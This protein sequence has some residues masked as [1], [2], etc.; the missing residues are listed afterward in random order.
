M[1]KP[2]SKRRAPA[3]IPAA[4]PVEEV[5]SSRHLA[6]VTKLRLAACS[7]GRCQFRGHNRD[8]Y[9]H[10]VT[11]TQGNYAEAA[12]IVAFRPR[13]ARGGGLRPK[14]INDFDNLMLLCRDCHHIVDTEPKNYPVEVLLQYKKEH[15]ERILELTEVGPEYRTTVV[16]LRGTIGGQAVDI[17]GTDIR[18]ALRP[19]YPARLPGVLIDL[20]AIQREDPSFFDLARDQIARE[21]RPAIRAE[22]ERKGVQHY[23]VFALAPI[24]VLV[25]LGREIGN[26]VTTDVFQKQRDHS[27]CWKVDG[28]VAEFGFRRIREG[29][30]GGLVALQ[31][32]VSGQ[33]SAGSLPGQLVH[34][35]VWE[36]AP[37]GHPPGVDCVRRREDLEAFRKSYRDCLTA[38]DAAYGKVAAI[39]LLP[40][41]PAPIAVACGQEIMPKAHA[42]LTVYDNV[43][44][45][46]KLAI[47]IN[48]EDDL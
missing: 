13:G 30:E 34:A 7:A 38:I 44:G 26:K 14:D 16:Q 25:C 36:I 42:A 41:V 48:T 10:P 6:L 18:T 9:L 24:P 5:T 47:T 23:S 39:H 19:R 33:I 32:S 3:T 35:A 21:L 12:H 29:S 22:L 20:T 1:A 2:S 46:F 31:L 43:K 17:P 45:A 15:E 40:A 37:K 11:G 4:S 8:L 28:P 27:W